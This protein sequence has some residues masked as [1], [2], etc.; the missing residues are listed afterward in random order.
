VLRRNNCLMVC[1]VLLCTG[2]LFGAR[3]FATDDAGTVA[4]G[5]HELE[6]GVDFWSE[7]VALG[8]GFKHGLTGRMDLGV[9]IGHTL[10]PEEYAGFGGAELGL[11]F[12][13]IPGFLAFSVTGSFG[14]DAYLLNG[15]ITHNL[16]P[17]EIDANFGYETAFTNDEDGTVTYMLAAILNT[18]CYAFGVEG[19]GEED[20]LQYWLVGGRYT[21][22]DGLA[23]D[24]GISGGF[25]DDAV[26]TA[27]AGFHYEF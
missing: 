5:I 17:I 10:A 9:G 3:P 4:Q 13:I 25:E 23:L 12:A 7:E 22:L 19:S 1:L 16:G 20:G 6:L 26:M 24:A 8:L 14:Q 18:G 11:K 15:I 21:L 2:L 27:T